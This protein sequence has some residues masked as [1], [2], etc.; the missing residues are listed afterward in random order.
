M[1]HGFGFDV[2]IGRDILCKGTLSLSQGN[3]VAFAPAATQNVVES[4]IDLSNDWFTDL[5]IKIV[6]KIRNGEGELGHWVQL[7][8]TRDFEGESYTIPVYFGNDAS[9]DEME[10]LEKLTNP[11]DL[12]EPYLRMFQIAHHYQ[13]KRGMKDILKGRQT[14]HS[15]R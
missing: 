1:P 7:R 8:F 10:R 12:W 2:L 4:K 11:Y 5:N 13:G 6:G 9:T 15:I 3:R 14:K